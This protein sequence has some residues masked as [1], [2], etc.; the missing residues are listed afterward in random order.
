[1]FE[2]HFKILV[3]TMSYLKI[4]GFLT[5]NK[6][7]HQGDQDV[8]AL[9]LMSSIF[10]SSEWFQQYLTNQKE[11]WV[12]VLLSNK[13]KDFPN[14]QMPENQRH[15]PVSNQGLPIATEQEWFHGSASKPAS[16]II[17]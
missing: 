7:H 3:W 16:T 15:I 11:W 12:Q 2:M 14:S 4:M 8:M 17:C 13:L 5:Y 6:A 10:I 9:A 1:M